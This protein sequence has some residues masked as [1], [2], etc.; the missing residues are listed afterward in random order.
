MK[1]PIILSAVFA[2]AGC[3]SVAPFGDGY[4][5]AKVATDT[6]APILVAESYCDKQG[7]V[8]YVQNAT[9]KSVVFACR[10][11]AIRGAAAQ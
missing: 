10:D 3:A 2:L 5:V 1:T 4:Y 9:P 7:K 6:Q 11:T 8:A